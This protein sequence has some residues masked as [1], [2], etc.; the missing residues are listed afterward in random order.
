MKIS[1][2]I[3][4]KFIFALFLS[5]FSSISIFFIFS[6]IGYLG[7][8]YVFLNILYLSFINS[9]QIFVNLP[10][11]LMIFTLFLFINLLKTKN[12]LII[13]KAYLNIEKLLLITVPFIVLFII[14]EM[15]K[16]KISNKLENFKSE[17]I[18]INDI[19]SLKVLIDSDNNKKIYTIFKK[20]NK[21]EKSI[22]EYLNFEVDNNII[23]RGDFSENLFYEN[24]SIKT[25]DHYTYKHDNFEKNKQEKK[26]IQNFN[27]FNET[28]SFKRI[29]KKSTNKK[30]FDY[31]FNI[32]FYLLFYFCIT[33]IFFSKK[34]V[35]RDLKLKKTTLFIVLIFLYYLLIPKISLN[36]LNFEFQIISLLVLLL[37]QINVLK[38]E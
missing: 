13:I 14:V 25:R 36:S 28:Q 8:S 6:L 4:K 9:L 7:E 11:Y 30:F 26:L 17:S 1:I 5:F 31:Y 23:I 29:I 10:S 35:L 3:F 15:N 2:Y 18:R 16:E 34:N 27:E 38:Y 32:I 22:K 12:E 19:E 24:N 21:K 20:I 33:I 37:I